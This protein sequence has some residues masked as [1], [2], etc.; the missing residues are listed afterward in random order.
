MAGKMGR[1]NLREKKRLAEA[2]ERYRKEY[3]EQVKKDGEKRRQ[4]EWDRRRKKGV[5]KRS[6]HRQIKT[7]FT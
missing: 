7:S 5:V 6:V 1:Y 3:E 2:V 4:K